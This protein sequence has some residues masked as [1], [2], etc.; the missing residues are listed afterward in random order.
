MYFAS[1][2][3]AYSGRTVGEM[4]EKDDAGPIRVNAIGLGDTAVR[5]HNANCCGGLWHMTRYKIAL[6]AAEIVVNR[7]AEGPSVQVSAWR[8]HV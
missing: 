1:R 8:H 6:A 5:P 2:I 3:A 7:R 4:G